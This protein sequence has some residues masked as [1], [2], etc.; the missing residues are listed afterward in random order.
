MIPI[1]DCIAWLKRQIRGAH[2][3]VNART[4]EMVATDIAVGL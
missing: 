1:G 3:T 2:V 4:K